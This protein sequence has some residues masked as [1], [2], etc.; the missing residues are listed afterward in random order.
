MGGDKPTIGVSTTNGSRDERA[1][2]SRA[3][4]TVFEPGH[5]LGLRYRVVRF[6]ARGGM[7]EV[8]EVEDLELHVVIALKTIRLERA[9]D[10]RH[11]DRLKREILLA[12]KITHPNVCRVFDVG[13][14][15]HDDVEIAF[16]TM[17]L[18]DGESLDRRLARLGPMS[19]VE[20]RPIV[21]QLA[22]ALEAAH[23]AGV[24]HRDV[25]SANVLLVGD[26]PRV[27]VTDFGLARPSDDG[28]ASVTTDFAGTPAYMAPEQITGGPIS[29]AADVYA[30]GVT[31]FEMV[32]GHC[33][34]E[35]VNPLSVTVKKCQEPAPPA[36]STVPDLDRRWDAAI[37]RCL[38]RD[39]ERRFASPLAF[40]AALDAD[41]PIV[42]RRRGRA[43]AVVAALAVG[44]GVGAASRVSRRAPVEPF[45]TASGRLAFSVGGPGV[46][47]I[48]GLAFDDA[49]NLY[50]AGHASAGFE[51]RGHSVPAF[52]RSSRMSFVISM[53]PDGSVRWVRTFGG[54]DDMQVNSLALSPDGRVAIGGRIHGPTE[55]GD[56]IVRPALHN[57]GVVLMLDRDRGHL[58]WAWQLGASGRGQ[59]RHVAF[60]PDGSLVVAGDYAGSTELGGIRLDSGSTDG[61]APFLGRLRR[62]GVPSWVR[63]ASGANNGRF[64]Q[65]AIA[66]DS[67][68]AVGFTNRKT[69]FDATHGIDTGDEIQAIAARYELA[70]GNLVWLRDYGSRA[71]GEELVALSVRGRRLIAGGT[72]DGTPTF[73]AIPLPAGGRGDALVVELS[74]ATGDVMWARGIA[75]P[76]YQQIRQVELTPSGDIVAMGRFAGEL[77]FAPGDAVPSIKAVE[78]EDG[79][80][81]DVE[82]GGRVQRVRSFGTR[83]PEK[84]RVMTRDPDGVLTL[85]GTFRDRLAVEDRVLTGRGSIEAF[86]FQ[87]PP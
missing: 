80:V 4:S 2:S 27:I 44:L 5:L 7:G 14:H 59:L 75:G 19:V 11:I 40:K 38:E 87:L 79:F 71:H 83:F 65:V 35:G 6:I 63:G 57:D 45:R 41:A 12:R 1:G 28:E 3:R 67:V 39:P 77:R 37:A 16:L 60:A 50:L 69:R 31:V 61:R 32:A 81:L 73:G 23:A 64:W 18:I 49:R 9:H 53:A 78:A 68:F 36:R 24:I 13:H 10:R 54:D 48:E 21:A 17:E 74:P 29:T 51:F 25:K 43:L 76:L 86:V 15:V 82:T 56:R 62:D 20:A 22:E 85:A 42:R 72:Y 46:E 30:L 84:P 33:P 8:Y 70:T 55:L 47:M 52:G 34:F 66:D 26:P 58:L